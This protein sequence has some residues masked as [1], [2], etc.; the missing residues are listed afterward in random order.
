MQV[1][2]SHCGPA[3]LEMLFSHLSV[4]I[5]QNEFVRSLGIE[6]RL[7]EYGM[8]VREME[9]VVAKLFPDYTFWY[10]DNSSLSDLS[11]VINTHKYPVGVEW[12]GDFPDVSSEEISQYGYE[13][14]DEDDDA[15]HYSVVTH[16]DTINN[17]VFVSDPFGPFAG[18]D[19]KFSILDFEKRW[20]DINEVVNPSNGKRIQVHDYHMMFL[21]T[22][23]DELFPVNFGM[24]T[25]TSLPRS[26]Y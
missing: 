13:E 7:K 21:V 17:A 24:S 15:G 20:W 23:K 6:S 3:V 12:Q 16:V 8:T 18:R 2:F 19:R 22:P 1:S 10:K 25:L 9:A 26:N 5:D 14:D 4:D 11:V